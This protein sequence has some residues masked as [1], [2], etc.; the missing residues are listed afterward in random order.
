MKTQYLK[1]NVRIQKSLILDFDLQSAQKYDPEDRK[2]DIEREINERKT[3]AAITSNF[4][5]EHK[6]ES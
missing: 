1:L 4:K 2:I 3:A 6:N 5:E